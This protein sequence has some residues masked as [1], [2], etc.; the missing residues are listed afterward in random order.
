MAGYSCRTE[1]IMM[2][3][4]GETLV[5]VVFGLG[6]KDASLSHAVAYIGPSVNW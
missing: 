5:H 3:N 4:K 1:D 6:R 2:S